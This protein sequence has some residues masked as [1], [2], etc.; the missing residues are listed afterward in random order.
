MKLLQ[1]NTLLFLFIVLIF[2]LLITFYYWQHLST[3]QT[4]ALID[5]QF[6]VMNSEINYADTILAGGCFWCV[7]ADKE[8]V[9]GVLEVVS[10]Y[11]GG[12]TDDPTYQDY[13][14]GGHR[15]VVKVIY[16]QDQVGYRELL[17]WFIKR[18]DP[19]DGQGS[20]GDRGVQYSPAIYYKNETE[21]T[22]AEEV[23]VEVAAQGIFEKKLAVAV[24]P[25]EKFWPA[26]EYHQDYSKKNPIRYNLYR[27]A[28]GRDAFIKKHWGEAGEI[29]PR[30]EKS[31]DNNLNDQ[32]WHL[33]KKPDSVELKSILTSLQYQVTQEDKTERAFANEYWDNEKEGIYVDILSGEPLFS[34]LDKYDSGTGWPSFTK[35]LEVKNIVT[36]SDNRLFT[37][38]IE[39]RSKFADSHLGH[40]FN[41]GPTTIEGSGGASPTGLRYCLNSAALRFIAK[42]DLV[43]EGYDQYLSLFD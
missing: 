7:E 43:K 26:E 33:Y 21:K 28:S 24:L 3:N 29:I 40:V 36:Q 32:S 31:I 17:S 39:V 4:R 38:R 10:G 19:T 12:N 15:E 2:L 18:I 5:K 35:P 1:K 11:S 42:E 23:L 30:F 20:F 22:I 9:P 37:R 16:D 14:A 8:K 41:D 27:R 34:S 6:K 25:E 13:S